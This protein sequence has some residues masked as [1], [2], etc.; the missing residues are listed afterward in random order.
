MKSD[1]S[2]DLPPTFSSEPVPS[3]LKPQTPRP[4]SPV[5]SCVSMKSDVSMLDMPTFSS[6]P[7]PS[8]LI[9]QRHRPPSPVP[10]CVSMKSD[11][12]MLDM[13]TF[14]SEP[15]PSDVCDLTLDPNTASRKLSL[16]E[17]NRKVLCREG[18]TGRCYWETEW[19]VGG[20]AD[21][22]VAY[23]SIE[24][25]GVSDDV[26][27]GRNV[28][29]WSLYCSHH[30][31]SAC[32]NNKHTIIPAPSSGSR[33]VG[34]YLDWPSGTLSFYSISTDTLTHLHTFHSTFTEPLYPGFYVYPGSSV[35][36]RKI[37]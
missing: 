5:P 36:L 1:V 33:T 18:L 19:S 35:S 37:T 2:I 13:P 6:G 9:P 3:G 30:R 34:V 14:S 25:K 12:S 29:S 22:S 7:V 17:E 8:G 32:H 27:M 24:R 11:R 23:K 26:I 31:Y 21:I 28:K 4:P 16:S 15:V 20:G 10:S